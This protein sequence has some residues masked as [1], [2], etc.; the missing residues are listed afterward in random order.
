MSMTPS[1]AG[2]RG[3]AET[4]KGLTATPGGR[5]LVEGVMDMFGGTQPADRRSDPDVV[6]RATHELALIDLT[7]DLARMKAPL[8]AALAS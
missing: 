1:T 2:V 5:R 6:A 3:L 7:D 8:W 4:L